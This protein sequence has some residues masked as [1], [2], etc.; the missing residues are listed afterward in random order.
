M[1]LLLEPAKVVCE[2]LV[3]LMPAYRLC[4]AADIDCGTNADV[5]NGAIAFE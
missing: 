3:G 2:L 5:E 4:Q 1:V